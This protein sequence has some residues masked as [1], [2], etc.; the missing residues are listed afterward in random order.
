MRSH[1]PA[2]FCG[3]WSHFPI[4]FPTDLLC[5]PS[6]VSTP[7]GSDSGGSCGNYMVEGFTFHFS[8]SSLGSAVALEGAEPL[9]CRSLVCK[10]GGAVTL[11]RCPDAGSGEVGGVGASN[12]ST[13]CLRL[14]HSNEG[15]PQLFLDG[16]AEPRAL[17]TTL[18][19]GV[20][21]SLSSRTEISNLPFELLFKRALGYCRADFYTCFTTGIPGGERQS[22]G[23]PGTPKVPQTRKWV[24]PGPARSPSFRSVGRW[25][26]AC[27][28]LRLEQAQ[29][30]VG[31]AR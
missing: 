2:L 14:S 24:G 9:S 29:A 26:L 23:S 25:S 15:V 28:L 11:S 10:G 6:W 19:K 7:S 13:M 30:S 8:I 31:G 20:A 12:N 27:W 4:F 16:Q 22:V 17:G 1:V 21:C 3:S 18:G 5:P